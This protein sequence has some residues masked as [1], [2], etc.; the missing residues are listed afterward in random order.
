MKKRALVVGA[1][2]GLGTVITK[3]LIEDGYT[4]DQKWLDDNRPDV[5]DKNAFLGHDED[6]LDLAIYLSGINIAKPIN[7]LT[8]DDIDLIF[9]TNVF[10]AFNFAQN[11]IERL[12]KGTNPTFIFISSIMV[13]HPYPFR[14]AYA[15]TKAA[16]EGLSTSLAIELGDSNISSICLRLG[17][18][19]SLMKSTKTNPA[20]LSSVKSLVPQHNLIDPIEVSEFISHIHKSNSK[21]LNGSVI[22]F[23]GGYTKNRWPL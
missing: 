6:P 8:R 23:D 21:T 2:G 5:W 22:D 13:S 4:L 3:N 18:L 1:T 7:E 15:S 17:H 11:N 9:K 12:K 20:L 16:I 10:G 14:T 19:S